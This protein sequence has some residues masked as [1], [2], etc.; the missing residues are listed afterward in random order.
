MKIY[1]WRKLFDSAVLLEA[2]TVMEM[3]DV[4]CIA[5]E[6][7][8][9]GKVEEDDSE[10]VV[11]IQISDGTIQ[12]MSCSCG[13]DGCCS[14][15]AAVLYEA[16]RMESK[17]DLES[18]EEK[19]PDC[20]G[21]WNDRTECSEYD[22]ERL[23]STIEDMTETQLRRALYHFGKRSCFLREN[24][25]TRYS[26][27]MT[28]EIAENVK[29]MIGDVENEFKG[30]DHH[31]FT[32]CD[33]VGYVERIVGILSRYVP[34]FIDSGMLQEAFSITLDALQT[35]GYKYLY[36]TKAI[37]ILRKALTKYWKKV[38]EESCDSMTEQLLGEL[39]KLE[40]NEEYAFYVG[41]IV[42]AFRN[43][44][45][46]DRAYIESMIKERLTE[47]ESDVE[48][49]ADIQFMEN[50]Q[51]RDAIFII[52]KYLQ[53]YGTD[54]EIEAFSLKY[55]HM[56][57]VSKAVLEY[58]RRY[59]FKERE[60]TL[61]LRILSNDNETVD[62]SNRFKI[63]EMNKMARKA[64]TLLLELKSKSDADDF[65]VEQL[66]RKHR[67]DLMPHLELLKQNLSEDKWKAI[68]LRLYP[69]FSNKELPLTDKQKLLK[70]MLN[71]KDYDIAFTMLERNIEQI[72]LV[73]PYVQKLASVDFDR[74]YNICTDIARCTLRKGKRNGVKSC[75][76]VFK[77]LEKL[78]P[79]GERRVAETVKQWRELF[80]Q[81]T[82][83][84]EEL[85]SAGF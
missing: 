54:D 22:E 21:W 27:E 13:V 70:L 72:Y 39:K 60:L 69:K 62:E 3:D 28:H 68:C 80:P 61:L 50:V 40:I 83:L 51:E 11:D 66:T 18:D 26:K 12:N 81:K 15:I 47:L 74:I 34:E 17:V 33:E 48:D 71:E 35:V 16:E 43:E 65:F 82:I 42:S 79:D 77:K 41:N 84:M 1:G 14:H 8:I 20:M 23:L 36:E 85:E 58:Y 5:K 45:F 76:D 59:G 46:D 63:S 75:I 6:G 37:S 2:R 25:I 9:H 56:K 52:T 67:G 53:G 78:S 4:A 38:I 32:I 7:L 57:T 10:Y 30:K 19:L 44:V 24:I 31:D 49:K 29:Y 64:Y 55:C 73:A